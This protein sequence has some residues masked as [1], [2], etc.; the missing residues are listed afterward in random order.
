LGLLA[1]LG[2]LVVLMAGIKPGSGS[3]IVLVPMLLAGLGMGML[4]SQLGSVTVSAVPDENSSEVGGLQNT[5]TNLGAALGTALAGSVLIASLTTA[6]LNNIESNPAVPSQVTSQAEVK[7]AAGAPFISQADLTA[8]LEKAGLDKSTTSAIVEANDE[9]QHLAL[10][11]AI[12]MLAIAAV[13]ALF[14]SVRI[15]TEQPGS[16]SLAGTDPAPEYDRV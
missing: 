9:A 3:G 12:A 7:L 16:R 6:F 15:P 14:A 10:R 8:R 2:G 5:M 4:A 11:I 1:L 13:L